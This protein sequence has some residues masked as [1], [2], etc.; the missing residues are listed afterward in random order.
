MLHLKVPNCKIKHFVTCCLHFLQ[1][2]I[3]ELKLKI[4]V[5]CSKTLLLILESK[6]DLVPSVTVDQ[7]WII[8]LLSA[9]TVCYSKISVMLIEVNNRVLC[10]FSD[11][12]RGRGSVVQLRRPATTST[13]STTRGG[14]QAQRGRR[15][16]AVFH[17]FCNT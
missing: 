15:L 7:I 9:I 11:L 3:F 12:S 4:Q 6:L 14:T 5:S 8:F 1:G 16:V 17:C 2:F 13:W 10:L